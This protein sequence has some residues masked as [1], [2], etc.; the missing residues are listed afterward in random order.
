VSWQKMQGAREEDQQE[1]FLS[2]TTILSPRFGPV[3]TLH[4]SRFTHDALSDQHT[5]YRPRVKALQKD[6]MW[7][8]AS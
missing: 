4:V 3:T 7:L 8:K 6:L 1:L 5:A 2:A